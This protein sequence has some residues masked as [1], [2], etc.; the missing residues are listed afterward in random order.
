MVSLSYAQLDAFAGN[1]LELRNGRGERVIAMSRQA[2]DSLDHEQ[3]AALEAN[4][5]IVS[6][7]IDNIESSA[8]GSVR[9]MLAEVHLP[10]EE[11]NK[12]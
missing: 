11:A 5:H 8:G 1:M 2:L 3:R 12:P 9:C 7:P 6:A 10:I 4:G